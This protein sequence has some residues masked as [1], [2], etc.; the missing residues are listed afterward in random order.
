MIPP[1][2]G[3]IGPCKSDPCWRSAAFLLGTGC[4]IAHRS[5]IDVKGTLYCT[6]FGVGASGDGTV[7]ALYRRWGRGEISSY[8]TMQ[9]SGEMGAGVSN[10]R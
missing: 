1:I 8:C 3:A 10:S 9:R 7:F 2:L 4:R 5:L 6:T